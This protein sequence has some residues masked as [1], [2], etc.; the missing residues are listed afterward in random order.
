MSASSAATT[1]APRRRRPRTGELPP[2]SPTQARASCPSA[3]ADR[4]AG[5][6]GVRR[7]G[8]G[9]GLRHRRHAAR[10]APL[11]S[12]PGG[13]GGRRGGLHH[14]LHRLHGRGDGA[15]AHRRPAASARG[16]PRRGR[17]PAAPGGVDGAG[18]GAC[19]AA[20]C[21]CFRRPS[22]PWPRPTPE[23][24]GEGARLPAGAGVVAAGVAAVHRLPRLQHRGVA[25]QGGDG[26]ADRRPGAEGAAVGGAGLRRAGARAAGAGRAWAAASPPRSRCGRRRW[27]PAWLLRRDP[28]YAPFALRRPRPATRP[29]GAALRAQLQAG[30]ADGRWRSW[31]RSRASRFMAIFIARLGTTP[32]AGHQIAANLVSLLFMM[33]LAHRQRHRHAGGAA[34]RRARRWPTRGAWAGTALVIGAGVAAVMGGGWSSCCASR[35]SACTRATPRCVAAALPL[36]AWVALFH[37]ADA[38]QTVAAFVLRAWRIATVPLVIYAAA[39]WGVGLGGGYC[40]GLRRRPAWCRRRC[41]ARR[42]FWV[43]ST[44]GPGR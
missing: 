11:G 18:A 25:A 14:R 8:L 36:L 6:A 29:T 10:G 20:R 17:A 42:G 21:C 3:H 22:W 41:T 2:G 16:R 23:V 38:A 27:R 28:F 33:P 5:L 15:R 24:A 19:W 40:A 43:A 31:S 26:A 7:P 4:A 13:A 12:R 1:A 44:T 9:A 34:H 30:R 32:V 39:L 37:V 35:C